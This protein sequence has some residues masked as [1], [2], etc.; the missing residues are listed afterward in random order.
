[1]QV[2][3]QLPMLRI[4]ALLTGLAATPL[5]S[6]TRQPVAPCLRYGPDT[7]AITGTLIRRTFFGAPGFGEDPKHDRKETGYYLDLPRGICTVPGR[8]PDVDNAKVG[9][10]RVQLVLDS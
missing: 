6:Q 4:A 5:P 10:R 1:M 3:P 9:V 2:F 7:V 8:D